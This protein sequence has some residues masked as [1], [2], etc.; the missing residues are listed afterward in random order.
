MDS[1]PLYGRGLVIDTYDQPEVLRDRPTTLAILRVEEGHRVSTEDINLFTRSWEKRSAFHRVL[2]GKLTQGGALEIILAN[3]GTA[4]RDEDMGL[5]A[6]DRK[7]DMR[8]G[9]RKTSSLEMLSRGVCAIGV[10]F[11]KLLSDDGVRKRHDFI[12]FRLLSVERET[13]LLF[14]KGG[15]LF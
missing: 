9:S 7:D 4:G 13:K 6:V 5:E 8:R 1:K 10:L 11:E 3:A 12:V 15:G 14:R 2:G